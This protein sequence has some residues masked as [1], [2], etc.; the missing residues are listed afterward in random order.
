MRKLAEKVVIVAQICITLVFA[1]ITLLDMTA[2]FPENEIQTYDNGVLTSLIIVLFLLYLGLSVYLIYVN[3]SERENVKQ[4]LLF[5]DSESATRTTAKV[6][7][8]IVNACAKQTTGVTV[9]KTKIRSDEKKGFAITLK[10]N[11][12]ADNVAETIDTFR[13]LL[14]DSFK[15]TLGLTFNTINFEINKLQTRYVPSVPTAEEKAE[16]LGDQR[17][18]TTEIYDNP[19][20][21]EIELNVPE[22]QDGQS[23]ENEKE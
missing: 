10:V 16:K 19:L 6:V 3:F 2:V 17:E 12:N 14:S 23:G 4:V 8:N 7:K 15:N 1:I 18:V 22:E 11:V 9:R 5:C 13:C 20:D 21:N